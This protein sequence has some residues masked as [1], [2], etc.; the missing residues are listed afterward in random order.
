MFVPRTN[1]NSVIP[2]AWKNS[3]NLQWAYRPVGDASAAVTM[4][5]VDE[6]DFDASTLTYKAAIS[7]TMQRKRSEFYFSLFFYYQAVWFSMLCFSV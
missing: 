2:A 4:G 7:R 3:E 1:E 5:S 6:A